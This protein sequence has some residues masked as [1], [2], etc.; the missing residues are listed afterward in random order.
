MYKIMK[1]SLRMMVS[2]VTMKQ[3]VLKKPSKKRNISGHK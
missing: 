2:N 3:R 1:K